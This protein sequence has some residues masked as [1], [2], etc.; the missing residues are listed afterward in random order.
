PMALA[1]GR[2]TVPALGNAMQNLTWTIELPFPG[3]VYWSVQAIDGAFIGSPFATEQSLCVAGFADVASGVTGTAG[4]ASA[5]GDYDNDGDLDLVVSG[6]P[7]GSTYFTEVYRYDG[8]FGQPL[9]NTVNAVLPGTV[10]GAAAW[11]D[12]DN[13]G[14]L[15]LALSGNTGSG[16]I[17]RVYRQSFG[18]FVDIGA[19][20]PGTFFGSLAW[21]D[22]DNDGDLDL[23]VTG[24][25]GT[26]GIS[27]IFRSSG[28]V[29]P[30]F[31]DAAAGLI[32]LTYS[33]VSLCDF[34][35]DGDL[36]ILMTG[37]T[38]GGGGSSTTA[39]LYRSSGG[40]NPTFAGVPTGITGVINGSHAWGDY[41]ADGDPDLVVCG[42]ATGPVKVAR[43]WR[44]PGG[45]TP[46]FGTPIASF[47]GVV[48]GS[49]AFGD[50][51]N[52][53]DL[54]ILIAGND[55]SGSSARLYDNGGG[56]N[57]VFTVSADPL[58]GVYYG[59]AAFGDM[60]KDHDL[61]IVLSGLPGAPYA[62]KVMRNTCR[63]L[64]TPPQPPSNLSV[65]M[66]GNRATFSWNAA[67]DNNTP[68]AAFTYNIRVGS[69]SGGS[70]IV[71]P[72]AMPTSGLRR[73]AARGNTGQ[74]TNCTIDLPGGGP[75]YWSVQ[76]IDAAYEGSPFATEQAIA[77]SGVSAEAAPTVTQLWSAGP[78]PFSGV[79][80]IGFSVAAKGPVSVT[81]IDPA[82]RLV[83]RLID[84]EL[85][86]GRFDRSWDGRDDAGTELPSG[87]YFARLRAG[88]DSR[89]L[90]LLLIK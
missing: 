53:G 5:W 43:L 13:D 34:D 88:N 27:R 89:V 84:G 48:S 28:G 23:V 62:T 14:D 49:A 8:V 74:R 75:W 85:E 6:T 51:D 4:G 58:P 38:A 46:T 11:G 57:P 69:T 37:R 80:S 44:N 52:D 83:R 7:D 68:A 45:P 30:V 79:A 71:S 3:P 39:M 65:S 32:G 56:A 15:D 10:Y 87:L 18:L 26:I 50:H 21:G 40:A 2:R 31:T 73:I 55:G 20:L 12:M 41:D 17:T 72:M 35:V 22:I 42:E 24:N 90:R 59:S 19:G 81:I 54:D 9:Y 63:P 78:N 67:V 33:A 1:T 29:D 70:E 47:T 86:P 36:D 16:P 82:G 61:D 64:N 76:A 25:D 60:D 66:V 77:Q